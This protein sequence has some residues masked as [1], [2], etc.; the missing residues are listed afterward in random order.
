MSYRLT[1]RR[2]GSKDTSK[3]AVQR[4]LEDLMKLIP[5]EATALYTTGSNFI[6]LTDE[7]E[8]FMNFPVIVFGIFTLLC[9]FIAIMLTVIGTGMTKDPE[10]KKY[11]VSW[12]KADK[13]QVAISA[14]AFILW[15]YTTGG[16]FKYVKGLWIP[17]FSSLLL[18]LFLVIVGMRESMIKPF[19][20]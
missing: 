17:W 3:T 20:K 16:I 12:K 18:V 5:A 4:L 10:K 8:G 13:G 1:T 9:L 6:P 2:A 19:D 14:A 7:S 15:V 11:V